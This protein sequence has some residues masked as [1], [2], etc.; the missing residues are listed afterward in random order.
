[1]SRGD[2]IRLA[3]LP[4]AIAGLQQEGDQKPSPTSL[5]DVEREAIVK[6][7]HLTGG[8]RTRAAAILGI[9]RK[10]LQNKIKEYGIDA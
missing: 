6:V 10:T 9:T 2:T 7:L 1:M 5:R 8:N 4:P 3:D